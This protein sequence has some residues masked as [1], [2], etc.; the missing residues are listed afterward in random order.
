MDFGFDTNQAP[1]RDF[2]LVRPDYYPAQIDSAEM[3]TGKKE[4]TGEMLK[5]CFELT[6]ENAYRGRKFW[7][8]L[9][10]NHQKE[11]TKEIARDQVRS[12]CHSIGRPGASRADELL[13][14]QL[15]VK[16]VT[17]EEVRDGV[18]QPVNDVTGFKALASTTTTAPAAKAAAPA[19]APQQAKKPWAR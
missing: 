13:G 11:Q 16:V 10:I 3:V 2:N 1:S 19:A 6:C 17:K 4:E 14:G 15:Q 9:C 8:Y 18:S 5:V 7:R 12:I